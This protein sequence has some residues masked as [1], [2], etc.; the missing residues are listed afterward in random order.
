MCPRAPA[1]AAPIRGF[2]Q[3]TVRNEVD[4]S[5][6]L[7]RK[8]VEMIRF[9]RDRPEQIRDVLTL[10]EHEQKRFLSVAVVITTCLG[11]YTVS[12]LSYEV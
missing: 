6:L 5:V 7:R 2:A 9:E 10:P 12:A 3:A 1:L 8:S 11:L 4:R